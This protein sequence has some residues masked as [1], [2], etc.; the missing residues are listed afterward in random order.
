[1]NLFRAAARHVGG[2]MRTG[3]PPS[4]LTWAVMLVSLEYA[5]SLSA[6]GAVTRPATASSSVAFGPTIS[7]TLQLPREYQS[8]AGIEW[9]HAG[10]RV[11]LW[12]LGMDYGFT[13]LP[14]ST[15]RT[16]WEISARGGVF[17]SAAETGGGL[18]PFGGASVAA[19]LRLASQPEPW[20]P[21]GLVDTIPLIVLEAG[22]NALAP[23][24]RSVVAEFST[25]L[26]L[27]VQ[28]SSSLLP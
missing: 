2:P 23:P 18:G 3:R 14:E 21:A 8:S 20:E 26:L 15:G 12:R 1:M 25:R 19:L 6:G 5:C 28:V 17:R 7:A 4:L 9:T 24:G 27:R 22:V 11:D 16:A 13:S 10:S